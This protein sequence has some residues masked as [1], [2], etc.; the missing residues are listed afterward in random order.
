ML[1]LIFRFLPQAFEVLRKDHPSSFLN[2]II[3]DDLIYGIHGPFRLQDHPVLQI[4]IGRIPEHYTYIMQ[5]P[6]AVCHINCRVE[7]IGTGL[8]TY[9]FKS[10][11][12]NTRNRLALCKQSVSD[13]Y[14]GLRDSF[15]IMW[16]P[17]DLV[18]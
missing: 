10:L 12:R 15:S 9:F 14:P 18:D 8:F 11:K 16:Q 13:Y 1:A 2:L 4:I 6:A 17:S 3:I 5:K 7:T